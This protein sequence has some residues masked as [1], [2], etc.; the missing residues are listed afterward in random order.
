MYAPS[1]IAAAFEMV[2]SA[3]AEVKPAGP[4]QLYVPKEVLE[5]NNEIVPFSQTGELLHMV[6]LGMG[7]TV[8]LTAEVGEIHPIK[9]TNK[10]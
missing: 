7:F 5:L 3:C 6:A 2:G 4:I 1:W 10:L 9:S 8:T